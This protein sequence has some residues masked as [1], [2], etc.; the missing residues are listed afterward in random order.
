VNKTD[1]DG[2]VIENLGKSVRNFFEA[3]INRNP[4]A[5]RFEISCVPFCIICVPHHIEYLLLFGSGSTF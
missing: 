5:F 3:Y 2:T 1:E 4:I